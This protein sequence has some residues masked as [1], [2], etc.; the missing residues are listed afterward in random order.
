MGDRQDP[1]DWRAVLLHG[2]QREHQAG[3]VLV[4]FLAAFAV[5]PR[6]EVGVT[7]DVADLDFSR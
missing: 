2:D 5:L 7:E 3:P 1:D 6:P 4:S